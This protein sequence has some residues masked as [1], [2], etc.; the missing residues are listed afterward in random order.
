VALPR[1]GVF[2]GFILTDQIKVIDQAVRASRSAGRLP[3]VI[4]NEVKAKIA[5]LLQI[6]VSS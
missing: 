4:L 6:P 5:V 3:Q 1:N 2:V